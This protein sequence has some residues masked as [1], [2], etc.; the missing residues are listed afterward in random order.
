MNSTQSPKPHH[1]HKSRSKRKISRSKLL[2]IIRLVLIVVLLI[3]IAG[4]YFLNIRRTNTIDNSRFDRTISQLMNA[5]NKNVNGNFQ[6]S[7]VT[8]ETTAEFSSFHRSMGPA[9][10]SRSLY[11]S[12]LNSTPE[13][14]TVNVSYR[15]DFNDGT[16]VVEKFI[17]LEQGKKPIQ[18]SEYKIEYLSLPLLTGNVLTP[19]S[20][21]N[22][23]QKDYDATLAAFDH[24]DESFFIRHQP[25]SVRIESEAFSR[26]EQWENAYG[27]VSERQ[28]ETVLYRKGLPRM[29][30]GEFLAVS[31][32]VTMTKRDYEYEGTDTVYLFRHPLLTQGEWSA[33]AYAPGTP[34]ISQRPDVK[35]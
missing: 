11:T 6:N 25:I 27:E 1:H 18:I 19:Y 8:P 5:V 24:A 14:K 9:K 20:G 23:Y 22:D 33:Y 12:S 4:L 7:F 15:S 13:G 35:K 26:F 28:V 21:P 3:A 31:S 10:D 29:E 30:D 2:K 34:L 32:V 16:V 17:L